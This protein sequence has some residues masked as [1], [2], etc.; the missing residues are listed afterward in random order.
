MMSIRAGRCWNQKFGIIE[1]FLLS[2]SKI[3]GK[4][5][6]HFN[7]VLVKMILN[8]DK[9]NLKNLFNAIFATNIFVTKLKCW[10]RKNVIFG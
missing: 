8:I 10:I 5:F 3:L 1:I 7:K 6:L 9:R 2:K 4:I